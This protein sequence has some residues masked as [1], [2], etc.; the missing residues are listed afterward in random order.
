MPYFDYNGIKLYYEKAGD[1]PPLFMIN[2]LGGDTR[3]WAFLLPHLNKSFT[4][5][6]YDMRCAGKSDKPSDP[7]TIADLSNEAR[8]LIEH[9][10]FAKVSVLGFSMGGMVAQDLAINHSDVID[11][12]VLVSTMPATM[13]MYPIP[14]F[15]MK[16]F[17]RTDISPKLI[18]MVYDVIFGSGFKDIHSPQEYIDFKMNDD[19]PQPADAYLNQYNAIKSFDVRKK[20]SNISTPT[21]IVAGNEDRVVP[22][23]NARWLNEHIS[24]SK[25]ATLDTVGHIVPLENPDKLATLVKNL[26]L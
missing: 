2:G 15:V 3:L 4:T 26:C 20:V 25:I 11:K 13:R 19:N 1:G 6:I 12:L 8:S 5:I 23:K 14:E 17:V 16:L 7:F 21:L 18:A 22:S 10:G 9:L 24:G